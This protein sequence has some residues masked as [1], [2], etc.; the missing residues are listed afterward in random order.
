MEKPPQ[1]LE[2]NVCS[3]LDYISINVILFD[4]V[5][6]F[7]LFAVSNNICLCAW[8][9]Q[10]KFCIQDYHIGNWMSFKTMIRCL[11]GGLAGKCVKM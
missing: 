2:P 1:F 7:V 4:F 6:Q 10:Y 5:V 11:T 8:G 3:N 9:F